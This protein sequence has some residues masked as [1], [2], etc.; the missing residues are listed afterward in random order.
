[1]VDIQVENCKDL[2]SGSK[3][4][5]ENELTMVD[6]NLGVSLSIAIIVGETKSNSKQQLKR[7]Q[8]L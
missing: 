3:Q 6:E 8:S 4:G 1:M 7:K 5:A 2:E